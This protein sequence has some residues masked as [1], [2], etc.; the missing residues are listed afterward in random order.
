ML[1][2]FFQGLGVNQDVINVA[3]TELI[4]VFVEGIVNKSLGGSRG[5]GKAK[6]HNKEFEETIASSEGGLPFITFFNPYLIKAGSEI[7]MGKELGSTD[8]I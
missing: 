3:D 8:L 6:G 4:E 7:K 1:P 2:V 5:I